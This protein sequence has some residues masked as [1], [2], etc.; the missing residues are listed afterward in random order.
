M[1]RSA[2]DGTLIPTPGGQRHAP[3]DYVVGADGDLMTR[4]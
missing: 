4:D 1:M 2:P 3:D